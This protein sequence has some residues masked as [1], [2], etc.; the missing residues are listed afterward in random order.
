MLVGDYLL[1]LIDAEGRVEA[2]EERTANSGHPTVGEEIMIHGRL[3][4]VERVRHEDEPENL[5]SRQYTF[6]KVFA[7]LCTPECTDRQASAPR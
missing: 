6:A 1:I 4:V 7:R 5:S 2:S 3:Y